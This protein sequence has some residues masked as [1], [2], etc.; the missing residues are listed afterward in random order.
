MVTETPT[1]A[2]QD[3]IPNALQIEPSSEN[4]TELPKRPL[5]TIHEPEAMAA[6]PQSAPPITSP[7][8]ASAS[9]VP[10]PSLLLNGVPMVKV[11][12]K[13]QKR[14]FFRLDPDEGQILYLS[15]KQ[16]ISERIVE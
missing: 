1:V 8:S 7:S 9:E 14:Y 4:I 12:A 10:I 6:P 11:S 2:S 5:S 15:K 13:K 3:E 16:R